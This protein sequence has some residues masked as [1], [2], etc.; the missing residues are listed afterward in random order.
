MFDYSK[1]DLKKQNIVEIDAVCDEFNTKYLGL[2][3]YCTYI[4]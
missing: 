1:K 2:L 4:K 3:K